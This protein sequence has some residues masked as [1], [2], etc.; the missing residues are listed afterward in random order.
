MKSLEL[1]WIRKRVDKTIPLPEVVYL[2]DIAGRY[3]SPDKQ[4]E[5]Y[6]FGG[7]PYSM[8]YG[9]IVINSKLDNDAQRLNIAHEW[10][11][12]WQKYNGFP[13]STPKYSSHQ[14]SNNYKLARQYFLTSISEL[15]A[16]RFS[17]KYVGFVGA[18][19]PWEELFYDLI[20]DLRVKRI[21]TYGRK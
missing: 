5:L 14:V 17:Y 8:K 16:L 13:F 12:H 7:K 10:R 15:D 11:H 4:N 21:I 6:D 9:V 1:N 19:K 3:Y 2:P 18:Y 20:R